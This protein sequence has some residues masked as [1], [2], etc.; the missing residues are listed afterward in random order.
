VTND[1]KMKKEKVYKAVVTKNNIVNEPSILYQNSP[2]NNAVELINYARQ[3]INMKYLTNLSDK[4]SLS[5]QEIGD[6]LHVSLR[7]LQRYAPTKVLDSD[8]SA[9][10]LNLAALQAHGIDVFGTATDFNE[11]LRSGVP[12]LGNKTPLSYLDTPFG[13]TLIDQTLGRIEHGLFA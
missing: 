9:K 12:H 13:F 11:W 6:I 8:A 10:A 3:G 2:L 1:R 4:L 7:T 5:L